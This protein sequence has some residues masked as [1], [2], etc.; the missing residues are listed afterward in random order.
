ME[1]TLVD[2]IEASL[3]INFTPEDVIKLTIDHDILKDLSD[4]VNEFHNHFSLPEKRVSEFRPSI[5]T[6]F[7]KEHSIGFQHV[8][9][10]DGLEIDRA[11]KKYLLFSHALVIEDPLVYLLDYFRSGLENEYSRARIPRIKDLLIQY[12]KAGDLIRNKIVFPIAGEPIHIN[13][14]AYVSD[15]DIKGICKRLPDLSAS[16]IQRCC[17]Q[18]AE[19][20]YSLATLDN[21]A[22]YFFP[23]PEYVEVLHE[24]IKLEEAQ[25]VRHHLDRPY[26][27]SIV[28]KLSS[29]N[30]DAVSIQDLI[31]IRMNDSVL[32]EWRQ[33]LDKSFGEL[34]LEAGQ[35][36]DVDSQ[37][38][39][40]AQKNFDEWSEKISAQL[41]KGSLGKNLRKS[42]EKISY[43]TVTSAA[44]GGLIGAMF[45]T[46]GAVVGGATGAI[47]SGIEAAV[48]MMGQTKE[49]IRTRSVN[50][51]FMAIGVSA[52]NS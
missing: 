10:V 52:K 22:D 48:D 2:V 23:R 14:I 39:L 18:I 40:I 41:F 5:S 42:L 43:G 12:A 24:I 30:T 25:Y 8:S 45:G 3:G 49:R 13:K 11:V 29:I 20:R 31:D 16:V 37:Y 36:S 38:R 21:R 17:Q 26:G 7:G 1:V 44:V 46:T 15:E 6:T 51:H 4:G 33:F 32:A 50:N 34:R 28:G 47:K 27:M 35:Y 9:G 19:E